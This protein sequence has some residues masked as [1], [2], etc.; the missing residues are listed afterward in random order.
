MVTRQ[1]FT[2]INTFHFLFSGHLQRTGKFRHR[3]KLSVDFDADKLQDEFIPNAAP[4]LLHGNIHSFAEAASSPSSPCLGQDA[5]QVQPNMREDWA[6][7]RIQ[8]AFRGFLV[9]EA[10]FHF[11]AAST[12]P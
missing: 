11:L 9:L 10:S 5:A 1:G 8:T 3:K 7:T 12:G 6:A 2:S 4:P